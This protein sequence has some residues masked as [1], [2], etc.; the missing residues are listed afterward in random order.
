MSCINGLARRA[1]VCALLLTLLPT[2]ALA[3]AGPPIPEP[4]DPPAEVAELRA[5]F[6]NMTPDQVRAAG[7]V[8]NPPMCISAPGIGGMGIHAVNGALMGSQ[9]PT[10]RMDPE[11]PSVVLLD[12]TQQKVI[13]LEWE[14]K[15]IG[16]GNME[17]FGVPIKL[18]QGHPG[19]PDPHYM[20]HVYFKPDGKVRMIGQD[21][22]FDPDV[23]CPAGMPQAGAG[24]MAGDGGYHAPAATALVLLAGAAWALRRKWLSALVV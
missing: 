20:L 13:G 7:Y 11:N 12:A 19:V 4:V 15:D 18:Q 5:R 6:E 8:A 2:L 21:P 24:G 16:Q 22:P 3:Q 14:A 23:T 1:L 17:M 10:G 9:F